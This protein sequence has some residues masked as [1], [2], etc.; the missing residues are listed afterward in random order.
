MRKENL[1]KRSLGHSVEADIWPLKFK[2]IQKS[3]S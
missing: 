2:G 1:K 3:T